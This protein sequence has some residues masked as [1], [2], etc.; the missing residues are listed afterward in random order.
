[1]IEPD[2]LTVT[3]TTLGQA[4]DAWARSERR[5]RLREAL[6]RLDGV[7]PDDVILSPARAAERGIRNTMTF[8]RGNIAPDGCVLKST[9]LDP[10]ILDRH[11]VLRM[12]GPARVFVRESDA[13]T[14][15]KSGKIRGGE[16][17]VLAGC[18]PLGAGM[19]ETYQLTSALRH[20]PFGR[21]VA[22]ITDARFSGASTGACI[23]HVGPEALAGGPIGKLVDQDLVRIEVDTV[24]LLG[25]I[26]FV[27]RIDGR[28]TP[29]EGAD[30]LAAR[31]LRGDLAV[32]PDVPADTRLWAALLQAGGGTWGGCVF[33]VDAIIEQLAAG[34]EAQESQN[35]S[36]S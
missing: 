15:I 31:P 3:G 17:I 13:I 23:G 25:S 34:R 11:G 35:G 7:D 18:G 27:G 36:N 4:L 1:V 33:D 24:G 20:L 8:P 22:L 6:L 21:E 10:A 2:V 28:L 30:V 26:D 19:E 16:I 14:A 9:S 29:K 5:S 12:E 32:A